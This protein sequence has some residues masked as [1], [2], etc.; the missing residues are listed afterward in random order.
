[1]VPNDKVFGI[2]LHVH[3]IYSWWLVFKKNKYIVTEIVVSSVYCRVPLIMDAEEEYELLE[4]SS[5][6]YIVL[7]YVFLHVRL[8]ATVILHA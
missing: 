5:L 3:S 6:T 2:L 7:L 4:H 8:L 1:M